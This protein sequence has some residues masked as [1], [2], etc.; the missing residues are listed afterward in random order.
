MFGYLHTALCPAATAWNRATANQAEHE[1]NIDKEAR[2]KS[3]NRF[4][5]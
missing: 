5:V 1:P 4:S 2:K 3:P